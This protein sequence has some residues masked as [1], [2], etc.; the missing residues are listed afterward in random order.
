M[1]P[2]EIMGK[3]AKSELSKDVPDLNILSEIAAGIR[4]SV[5][6]YNVALTGHILRVQKSMKEN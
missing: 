6:A 2:A 5:I 3:Y 1:S 4:R